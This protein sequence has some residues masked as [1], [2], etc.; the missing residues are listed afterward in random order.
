LQFQ[1]WMFLPIHA[2]LSHQDKLGWTTSITVTSVSPGNTKGGSITA[3]LTSCLTG[4]GLVCFANK[5]KNG[6]LSYSRF[7]TSQTGGQQYSDTS[8][9]SIPWRNPTFW[10]HTHTHTHTHT[11]MSQTAEQELISC[12][13]SCGHL[14]VIVNF[15]SHHP[16]WLLDTSPSF[17][18]IRQLMQEKVSLK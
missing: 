3:P 17:L 9:F 5:N 1:T 13:C 6:Q 18:Y 15:G 8:P 2:N 10:K 4:F 16:H 7:Q 12:L 11:L 14:T